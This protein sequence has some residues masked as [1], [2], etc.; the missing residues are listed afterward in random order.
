MRGRGANDAGLLVGSAAANGTI[1]YPHLH[2]GATL[3][4]RISLRTYKLFEAPQNSHSNPQSAMT[5][6]PQI[7][8]F[9]LIIEQNFY[10]ANPIARHFAFCLCTVYGA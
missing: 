1:R 7:G 8:T 10:F 2:I 3:S 5:L 6:T 9:A 4:G